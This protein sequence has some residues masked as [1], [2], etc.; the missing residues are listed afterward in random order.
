[1]TSK[2]TRRQFLK[3][4]GIGGASLIGGSYATQ[5]RVR[6]FEEV[7]KVGKESVARGPH[8]YAPEPIPGTKWGMVIDVKACI[9]CRTC[10]EACFRE[11]NID[12]DA[13][14]RYIKVLQMEKGKI[15]FEHADTDYTEINKEEYWYIPIQC[16][17]CENPP[18]VQGCPVTAT[19]KEVDGIVVIDYWKCI[20]CRYCI[21]NCPYW[22]RHFNW[23]EPRVPPE[24]VNPEVPIRPKGVV[25][26]CTFCIHR[27]RKGREPACVE[28]CPVR[29][30]HFGDLNDPESPVSKILKERVPFRLKEELGTNPKI[31]Y[32]G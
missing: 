26:K 13:S 22:A 16:M 25:E 5:L 9:G 19:W 30:R 17:Q 20:G 23:K 24:E 10:R 29:A 14:F 28:S 2:I 31:W 27:T 32:V 6:A 7:Y 4:L 11:N 18:C 8:K 12:R 1:M 15:E 3:M 21:I